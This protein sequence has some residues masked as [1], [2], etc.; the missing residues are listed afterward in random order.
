MTLKIASDNLQKF[1]NLFPEKHNKHGLGN[2]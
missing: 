2:V 1:N